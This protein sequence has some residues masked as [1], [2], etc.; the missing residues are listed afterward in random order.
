MRAEAAVTSF[1][2]VI[3]LVMLSEEGL[4]GG[5]LALPGIPRPLCWAG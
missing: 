4:T 2:E 3:R 5:S 1:G